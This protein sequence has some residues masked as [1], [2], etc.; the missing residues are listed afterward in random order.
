M[1]KPKAYIGTVGVA[2][3]PFSVDQA[4]AK[5]FL[6]RNYSGKLR[7]RSLSIMEKIFSHPSV[8]KRHFA[9]ENPDCLLNES[10]DDRIARFTSAAVELSAEAAL[11]SLNQVGLGPSDVSGLVA[12]TCTGYLCPG[13]STYIIERLGLPR[14]IRAY[15]LVGAGCGG[16]IPN[17]EIAGHTLRENEN[18]VVLSISVE[19]CSATFQMGDDLSLIVSNMLFSDGAAAAVVWKRAQGLELMASANYCAPEYRGDLR[20]IY[21]NGQLHNRISGR[22]PSLVQG[23]ALHSLT[24]ILDPMSLETDEI[25]HWAIHPGGDKIIKVIQSGIGLSDAQLRPARKTLAAYGNMSSPSVLF[26]LREILET[27][28]EKDDWCVMLAFGAGLSSHALL[29]KKR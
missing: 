29:L 1:F 15:D 6:I 12:S 4:E 11:K 22:L 27:G 28:I 3:P 24:G 10:P 17:L 8:L 5:A 2:V 20:Y 18:G 13:L 7:P 26:V 16:A 14:W 21:K 23:A 9:F 19:I 25:K